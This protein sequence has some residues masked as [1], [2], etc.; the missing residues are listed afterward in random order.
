MTDIDHEKAAELGVPS[1]VWRAG[2]QRRLQMILDAAGERMKGTFFENGALELY[3]LVDDPG[4]T[5]NV[6]AEYP[7]ITGDFI[8]KLGAWITLNIED[9]LVL[10]RG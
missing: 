9:R 4:E 10:E 7:H 2:Q 1:L 6:F 5:E 3:N 8:K